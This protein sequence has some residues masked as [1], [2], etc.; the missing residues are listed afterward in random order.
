MLTSG[1]EGNAWIRHL[2][3]TRSIFI[4]PM[5]NSLGYYQDRREENGMD[6]NRDFPIDQDPRY[7]MR[8]ITARAVNELWREHMFQLAITFHGG[9]RSIAYEWGTTNHRYNHISPDDSAQ[10]A[11]GSI[12]SS[13]AGSFT[14]RYPHGPIN[15][16]VY[17]VR[18]GMED[19]GYADRDTLG[20][21]RAGYTAILMQSRT[22][23]IP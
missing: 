10:R 23:S 7:C 1:Y 5:T 22:A 3:D 19:W 18:G 2:V 14:G 6:P 20:S 11:I 12:M 15:A 21:Q 13:Y 17:P 9:M 4:M 8:T 16:Q